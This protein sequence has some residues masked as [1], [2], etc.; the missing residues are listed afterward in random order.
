MFSGGDVEVPMSPMSP[1][2]TLRASN[3][4]VSKG[5][6][7]DSVEDPEPQ[8]KA[9]TIASDSQSYK[10][11]SPVG[12]LLVETIIQLFLIL[13]CGGWCHSL[14]NVFLTYRMTYFSDHYIDGIL[15]NPPGV[16]HV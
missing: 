6:K 1:T 7:T 8:S 14:I 16:L 3:L 15:S 5:E 13:R 2:Q 12:S 11:D 10:D 9:H 4:T